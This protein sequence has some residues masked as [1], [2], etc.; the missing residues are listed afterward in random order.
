MENSLNNMVES[1][2]YM[3]E[4]NIPNG[5]QIAKMVG[6][7]EIYKKSAQKM[8]TENNF[9]ESKNMERE[10]I[11]MTENDL[12]QIIKESVKKMLSEGLN[13]YA[14]THFAVNKKTNLIVNGW[15]YSDHDSDELKQFK[16]D[17][18]DDDLEDYGFNPKDYKILS[19]K[20]CLRQGINPDD[21]LNCWSNDGEMSLAQE[22]G[23]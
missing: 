4:N 21:Q 2:Q 16:K 5:Y 17:Y 18:F 22:R 8:R 15:D 11:R 19:R 3:K 13:D 9:N 20:A 14:E 12:H 23:M 6:C 1:R 10:V 7:G